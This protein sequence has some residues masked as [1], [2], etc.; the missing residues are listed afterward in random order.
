MLTC[1]TKAP[2]SW[3]EGE[4]LFDFTGKPSKMILP[5]KQVI[6][7]GASKAVSKSERS[8]SGD[9][10]LDTRTGRITRMPPSTMTLKALSHK[11][12]VF[13]VLAGDARLQ[14]KLQCRE[15]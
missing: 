11:N 4:V 15:G 2:K 7:T 3:A 6:V 14:E 5:A 9:V 10:S 12:G 8:M 13:E 1:G